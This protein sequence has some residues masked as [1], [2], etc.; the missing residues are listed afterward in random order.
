MNKRKERIVWID[1]LKCFA[2]ICVV[3]GHLMPRL[4]SDAMNS[5]T[6]VGF[7]NSSIMAFNMPLFAVLSGLFFSAESDF[8]TFLFHKGQQLLL[9]YLF[10]CIIS[11][12]LIPNVI[13][14][15]QG[16]EIHFLATIRNVY[17]GV[18]DWGWWFIRALLLCFL[19]AYVSVR[20][21]NR[22][23]LVACL[24]SIITLYSLSFGGIIPNK[25]HFSIGF[26][27]LYPFFGI[28]Y[29]VR[30]YFWKY[31]D[32]KSKI[33]CIVLF[34]IS[35]L[36]F[37]FWKGAPD[38]FY[39]MNTSI[40]ASSAQVFQAEGWIVVEKTVFRFIFGT[41]SSLFFLCLFK[42]LYDY[43]VIHHSVSRLFSKMGEV[44][45]GIYILQSFIFENMDSVSINLFGLHPWANLLTNILLSF[46][47]CFI[48]YLVV[49]TTKRIRII[50]IMLWGDRQ[51]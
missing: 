31:I 41:I 6:L 39:G 9:P 27:F 45:L 24:I 21:S 19:F 20:I 44:T 35:C 36:I 37:P 47:I 51:S 50:S 5:D 17:W 42:I 14:L 22:N 49:S 2:I 18:V 30:H 32:S 8:K 43:K 28:G 40:F 48:L 15:L 34:G 25:L 7:V 38:T 23:Y 11:F 46:F 33:S 26:I 16:N 13:L 10:W 1:W 4:S 3:L 12:A 29:I